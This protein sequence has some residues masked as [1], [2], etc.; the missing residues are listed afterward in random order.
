MKK[1]LRAIEILAWG[2]FFALAALVLV[3]RF[4]VLPDIERFREPI[5]AAISQAIGRPVRVGAIEAG[6]LGLR[7]EIRLSDVRRNPGSDSKNAGSER[8]AGGIVASR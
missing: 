3:V 7:P 4:W 1:L 6:W 8:G 5:V 2:V